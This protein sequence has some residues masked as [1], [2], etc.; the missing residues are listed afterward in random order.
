LGRQS[1]KID[2]PFFSKKRRREFAE[3]ADLN[4]MKSKGAARLPLLSVHFAVGMPVRA[5]VWFGASA[6][7]AWCDCSKSVVVVGDQNGHAR[8][9]LV[10]GVRFL[11]K[12]PS[13]IK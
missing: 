13:L 9:V 11:F 5:H 8:C 3:K 2:V 1:I 12:T 6:P 10:E 7:R 4:Y